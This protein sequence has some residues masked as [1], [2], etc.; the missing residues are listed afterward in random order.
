M[1]THRDDVDGRE[2]QIGAHAH[3]RNRDHVRFQHRIAH[4]AAH[5]HLGDRVAHQF[6]DAQL[7]LR[8]AARR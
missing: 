5:E 4:V 8:A 7:T 3:F 2:P 1:A 6:A